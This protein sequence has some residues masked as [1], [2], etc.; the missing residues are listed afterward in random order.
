MNYKDE[1]TRAMTWLGEQPDTV[2]LGQAVACPGTAMTG[3]LA[4]V[5][6]DKLIELPV[7]E[8]TQLG[9]SIGMAL[10]GK[11]V[12]SIY[13]RFN[14]L[15]CA[16]NQLI[17]HLDKL[18]EMSGRAPHVII[19]TAIGSQR[20]MH[21][22]PQHVGDFTTAFRHMASSVP[23]ITL[24]KAEDVFQTYQMAYLSRGPSV[25][26]EW[27]DAYDPAW[28]GLSPENPDQSRREKG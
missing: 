22:G 19:R 9:M 6:K 10:T 24:D 3:T 18:G 28:W 20:P 8:D 27:A 21:P 4:N 16:M 5:P 26:V 7:F 17:N 12:V 25:T 13:P 14:F 15:L 23:V 1:L 11:A 2:F